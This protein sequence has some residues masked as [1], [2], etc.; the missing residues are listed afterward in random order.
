[1]KHKLRKLLAMVMTLCMIIPTLAT[2]AAATDTTTAPFTDIAGHWA[3]D[4]I[5]RW[6]DVGIVNGYPDGTF[7][8][9][10]FITRAELAKIVT[11]AFGLTERTESYIYDVQ[12]SDWYYDYVLL[13]AEEIPSYSSHMY[14]PNIMLYTHYG[15]MNLGNYFNFIPYASALRYHVAEVF[16]VMKQRLDGTTVEL[17]E[18]EEIYSLLETQYKDD[19][20]LELRSTIGN[21]SSD[22]YSNVER[23]RDYIYLSTVLG[24]MQGKP[25]EDGNY[26]GPFDSLTR[27]EVLTILDRIITPEQAGANALVAMEA[28]NNP[29][30]PE[31]V[32][33]PIPDGT[34]PDSIDLADPRYNIIM[35]RAE[36]AELLTVAFDLDGETSLELT[37]VDPN[38]EYYDYIKAAAD[39]IPKFTGYELRTVIDLYMK[40][41]NGD[42]LPDE[43]ILRMHASQAFTDIYE[44]LYGVDYTI[45]GNN[46]EFVEE[47]TAHYAD[48]IINDIKFQNYMGRGIPGNVIV[49]RDAIYTGYKLGI[50]NDRIGT[51]GKTYFL[52]YDA[53]TL[54]DALY[55]IFK[56]LPS[57]D[58]EVFASELGQPVV[59]AG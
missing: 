58:A 36:F 23:F 34:V 18:D 46:T 20:I 5:T 15:S 22:G 10:E 39:Y 3:E 40:A 55:S 31:P 44:L 12:E 47:M 35:T 52:P 38:S 43:I 48:G 21:I 29:V 50:M 19:I 57:D 14:L 54:S 6:A 37:D 11:L 24:I 25:G 17:P 45:I 56:L 4:T 42:F 1:M 27:A 28:I 8:P 13:A 2:G 49:F 53:L 9:D 7:R 32:E 33:F 51:D 59:H 26:F 41:E 16:T 30:I